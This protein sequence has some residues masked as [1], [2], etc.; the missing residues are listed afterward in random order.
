[1]PNVLNERLTASPSED[2]LHQELSLPQTTA[3]KSEDWSEITKESLDGLPQVWTRGLLYFLAIFVSIILPWAILSK[4]DETGTA[5]GRT[6][7][8]DKTIKL[9]AA[10]AGTVAEIR[11]K[12]GD[13]VKAG[14][15]LLLL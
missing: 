3:I 1:M 5:R 7:P 2:T 9:D 15:T 10:V 11:V 14:E 8:K 13:S 12:E 4:V 6:E